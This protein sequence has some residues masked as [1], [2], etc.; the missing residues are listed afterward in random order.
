[1]IRL[2]VDPVDGWI[3]STDS[4]SPARFLITLDG[5]IDHGRQAHCET[6]AEVRATLG[7]DVFIRLTTPPPYVPICEV[8]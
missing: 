4:S 6:T 7:D 3:V 2:M 8:A 5:G 1:M